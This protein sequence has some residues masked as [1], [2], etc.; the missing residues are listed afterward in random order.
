M[1]ATVFSS[2]LFVLFG[3]LLIDSILC[4]WFLKKFSES[5]LEFTITALIF[6]IAKLLE[7]NPIKELDSTIFICIAA[8]AV[9]IALCVMF[10]HVF[11]K[12]IPASPYRRN[13]K[14]RKDNDQQNPK[15]PAKTNRDR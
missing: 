4:A 6:V 11:V 10:Y 8:G 1:T 15:F 12:I 3:M 5:L 13:H 7:K 9:T 14:N 2:W